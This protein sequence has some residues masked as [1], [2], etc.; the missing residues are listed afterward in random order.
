MIERG[1][2][3]TPFTCETCGAPVVLEVEMRTTRQKSWVNSRKH[4]CSSDRDHE[5]GDLKVNL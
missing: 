1:Q 2:Q 4:I 5:I 3:S